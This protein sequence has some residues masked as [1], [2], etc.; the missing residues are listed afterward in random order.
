[1]SRIP[2]INPACRRTAP[3]EKYEPGTIDVI[4][5]KCWRL[6]PPA[7]TNHYRD[8][9]RR[10]R[11]MARLARKPDRAAQ[12]L[13]LLAMV[14]AAQGRNWQAIR[15]QFAAPVRPVGLD[16]FLDEAGFAP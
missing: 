14:E 6:L 10:Q 5:P 13:R 11:Q 1:M 8:L 15:Q 4:C 16:A 9:A 12:A 2:C 3:A 7:L